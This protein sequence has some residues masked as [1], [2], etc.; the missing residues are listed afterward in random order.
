MIRILASAL[1]LVSA[2]PVLAAPLDD[3]AARYVRMSLEADTHDPG[4]VDAYYGPPAWR[5]AAIAAPRS[6]AALRAEAQTLSAAVEGVQP[7][8]LDAGQRRR[9][10]F[11][12]GQLRAAGT[13]LAMKA[14]ERLPFDEEASGLFSVR[15]V[16]R[17]L[18]DLDPVIARVAALA[19]CG[20]G[21]KR[22]RTGMSCRPIG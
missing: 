12:L 18:S 2:G 17:P 21:W 3:L 16:L 13:R 5:Q 11:L 20:S 8:T 22:C 19:P 7:A 6:L 10:A 9:R 15:P 14:G 1:A 4:Y